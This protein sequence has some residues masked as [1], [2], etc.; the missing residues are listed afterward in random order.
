MRI[1]MRRNVGIDV[2]MKPKVISSV[3]HQTISHWSQVG[4]VVFVYVLTDLR[5]KMDIMVTLVGGLQW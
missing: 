2:H 4:L 1:R 5:R 3:D